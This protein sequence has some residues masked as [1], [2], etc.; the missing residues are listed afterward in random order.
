VR[1][2]VVGY[3]DE[4]P[5]GVGIIRDRA[6]WNAIRRRFRE[7]RSRLPRDSTRI[8]WS[9]EMVLLL[10]YGSGL[11]EIEENW[12]F[13]RAEIRTGEL[14]ITLGPDSLV[15]KREIFID[16]FMSPTAFAMPRSNLATRYEKNVNDGW[17]P[18]IVDWRVIADTT[19]RRNAS[20]RTP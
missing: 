15:G 3:L 16:G 1:T 6:T 5:A 17:I 14:V 8:D 2:R 11:A 9:R 7:R 19:S 10:S 12:G 20:R 18:P 4:A 13:N